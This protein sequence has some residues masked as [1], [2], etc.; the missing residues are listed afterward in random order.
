MDKKN[1]A[2]IKGKILNMSRQVSVPVIAAAM[3]SA[4][5][6][7]V[8]DS[9]RNEEMEALQDKIAELE[10]TAKEAK[11]TQRISEQMEDIAFQ[12]KSISDKQRE[13]AENQKKIADIER[14]KA[15]IERGLAQAAERKALASAEEAEQMRRLADE[16]REEA[17]R[18]MK[19]AE[20]A[21]AQ[22][23]T[24]YY[25]S[26]GSTLAQSAMSFGNNVSNLSRLLAYSSWY[27]TT[28]YGGDEY[29]EAVFKAILFSSGNIE[30][31]NSVLK[32]N[33]R[34]L[35][36]VDIDKGRCAL[37]VT[38]IGELFCFNTKS[39]RRL[40]TAGNFNFRD[41]DVADNEVFVTITS[42]GIVNTF[43][44]ESMAKN[45]PKERLKVQLHG[46]SQWRKIRKLKNHDAFIAISDTKVIWLDAKT[47]DV[48]AEQPIKGDPTTIGFE[49]D[50]IHIFGK[51]NT[52]YISDKPGIIA[53]LPLSNIDMRITAYHYI[54]SYNYHVIGT[55]NGDIHI[56]DNEGNI[57]ATLT[58]HEGGITALGDTQNFIV[59]T[60]YDRRLRYWDISNGKSIIAN[61][62]VAFDKWPLTFVID[63]EEAMIW[64]G[65]SD[66]HVNRYCINPT[67]NAQSTQALITKDFTKAEWD[68]YIGPLVP[69]RSFM[70]QPDTSKEGG[71][72]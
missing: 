32:G 4:A 63:Q 51:D 22:T 66:G 40:F 61:F 36:V 59:S 52:H 14:G 49:N 46:S 42:D 41:M 50:I 27:Y 7:F 48:I 71:K 54:E 5:T 30:R 20:L 26:L 21:R 11:V 72:E 39:I 68:R 10:A 60:G 53:Q 2:D 23:D 64:I 37:G 19:A 31:I 55:E 33:V 70:K 6:Y 16:Q 62:T 43:G 56:I 69:Y 65:N 45:M 9:I 1:L 47:L 18:N 3:A 34:A 58:G 44:Y 67:M 12:Q 28:Q 57:T 13:A 8:C 24:L 17:V 29:D 15:E 35:R 25:L 38:D